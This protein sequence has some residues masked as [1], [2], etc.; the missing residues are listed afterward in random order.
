MSTQRVKEYD[1]TK[2][3]ACCSFF[4]T[5]TDKPMTMGIPITDR[6]KKRFSKEVRSSL[7]QSKAE[8]T[9]D[10]RWVLPARRSKQGAVCKYFSGKIGESCSC[11]I[12]EQRPFNCRYFAPDADNPGCVLCRT[13]FGMMG[14]KKRYSKWDHCGGTPRQKRLL[15]PYRKRATPRSLLV[16]ACPEE[17]I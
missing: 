7:V 10:L 8:F 16:K 12:Y 3:G 13:A 9:N 5:E 15:A 6:D 11:T 1:C 4:A 14:K 2:C 17:V